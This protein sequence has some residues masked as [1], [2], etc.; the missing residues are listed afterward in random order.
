MPY[1]YRTGDLHR[2]SCMRWRTSNAIVI[3]YSNVSCGAS[4]AQSETFIV[5]LVIRTASQASV[6]FRP[7]LSI[8]LPTQDQS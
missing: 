3:H 5:F 1:E 4:K 6:R 8:G 7:A 2:L